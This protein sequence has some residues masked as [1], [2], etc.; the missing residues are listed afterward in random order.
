VQNPTRIEHFSIM[1]LHGN[2]WEKTKLILN[3]FFPHRSSSS[4]KRCRA[5]DNITKSNR[6]TV[7]APDFSCQTAALEKK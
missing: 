5:T 1:Q 3:T 6:K 4:K 7:K 2:F